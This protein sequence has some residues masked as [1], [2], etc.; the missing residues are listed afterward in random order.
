MYIGYL[1]IF[2]TSHMTPTTRCIAPNNNIINIVWT[3]LLVGF[4]TYARSVVI[5]S[6]GQKNNFLLVVV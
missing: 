4:E 1:T 5:L 3:L 6:N 2:L